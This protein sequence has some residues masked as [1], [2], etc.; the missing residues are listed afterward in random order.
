MAGPSKLFSIF[1]GMIII[2]MLAASSALSQSVI[3]SLGGGACGITVYTDYFCP[4]CKRTDARAESLLKDLLATGR[5]KVTFVD[6]PFN[7][8]TPMYARYYLQAVNA[9]AETNHV[10]KVRSILFSAAQEKQILTEDALAAYLKKNKIDIKPMD[11][12]PVFALMSSAIKEARVERTPTWI[13]RCT[14]GDEKKYIGEEQIMN[15]LQELKKQL[16]KA[17]K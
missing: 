3:P 7:R 11:E 8:A 14:P 12:K 10:L 13:V 15:G 6:V 5:V 9:N 16:K 1:S 2:V 4:P 17:K